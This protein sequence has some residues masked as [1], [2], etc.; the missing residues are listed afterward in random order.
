M[1]AGNMGDAMK[2]CILTVG[3][4]ASGKTTWA[5]NYVRVK[6]EKGE[7]WININSDEIRAE[8]FEIKTG[9][10][11]FHWVDWKIKWEKYVNERRKL[12]IQ[13]ALSN[14]YIDGVVISNTNLNPKTRNWL[15][16]V[17]EDAG[18]DVGLKFFPI[19]YEEAVN[20]DRGRLNSVGACVIAE[21]IEKY[22]EQF[23]ERYVGDETLP[24]AVIV[25]IDGT[26]A[27]VT[28]RGI[29]DWTA[30][31]TDRPDIMVCDVVRGL[32]RQGYKIIVTSGRDDVSRDDT[33][34]WL[35]EHL[36]FEP[37][38]LLM[39]TYKD[40]RKDAIVKKELFDN[41]ICNKYNV[42]LAIDDRPCIVRLWRSLGIQTLACGL[43]HKEF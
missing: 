5:E 18:W 39:R 38:E 23:G 26:L 27:H 10:P 16:K 11:R 32:K 28:D 29:Y 33:W 36:G 12:L 7:K 14:P 9:S 8:I 21:Q 1:R 25:D 6:N 3:I 20:R 35:V 2:K 15:T 24:K 19:E 4:S 31:K 34:L 40:M 13:N 43:Q 30:V 41:F 22:W 37:N 17:F 42:V